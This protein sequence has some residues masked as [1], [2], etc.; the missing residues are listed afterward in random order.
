MF[1][2]DMSPE[3]ETMRHHLEVV[4]PKT[5]SYVRANLKAYREYLGSL[6]AILRNEIANMQ[7][8]I[9]APSDN[10]TDVGGDE[11][12]NLIRMTAMTYS[13]GF[14]N[15]YPDTSAFL[16]DLI[17]G[18]LT[19]PAQSVLVIA[20]SAYL[21]MYIRAAEMLFKSA[22]IDAGYLGSITDLD[23]G[24]ME[25][26]LDKEIREMDIG[27]EY[28]KMDSI[29][30]YAVGTLILNA[31]ISLCAREKRK[32]EKEKDIQNDITLTIRNQNFR[33]N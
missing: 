27:R 28:G 31:V 19:D 22:G 33:L 8:I 9:D 11:F 6:N 4:L 2:N 13:I 25:L 24:C 7:A 10:Y 26:P 30:K 29:D 21:K 15:Q 16:T 12:L 17:E 14:S 23:F 32:K 3:S 1:Y 5:F 18:G 20:H